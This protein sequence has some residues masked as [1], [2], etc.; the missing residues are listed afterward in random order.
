MLWVG[1]GEDFRL[2]LIWKPLL[3]AIQ[4]CMFH[5]IH[6]QGGVIG[7]DNPPPKVQK[8]VG[9]PPL[10]KSRSGQ[11]SPLY[12]S[13]GQDKTNPP[14]KFLRASRAKTAFF[15]VSW[16]KKLSWPGQSPPLSEKFGCYHP[17]NSKSEILGQDSYPPPTTPDLAHVCSFTLT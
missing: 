9:V 1:T 10:K 8:L 12:K 16:P 17:S 4:K 7:Q 2:Y 15:Q 14:S 3:W 11:D 13:L 5:D 6:Q